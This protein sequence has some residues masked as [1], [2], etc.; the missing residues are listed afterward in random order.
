MPVERR[1]FRIE[2][3]MEANGERHVMEPVMDQQNIA[4]AFER[5]FQELAEIRSTISQAPLPAAE[6]TN[7][8]AASKPN[9]FMAE[10]ESIQQ[11]IW[12][13]KHEIVTLQVKGLRGDSANRVKDELDAVVSGTETATETILTAAE[14]IEEAAG[15]LLKHTQGEDQ[16]TAIEIHKQAI[17]IFEAC[18]FQDLTGQRITKVVQVLHFIEERVDS[19]MAI[20]GGEEGFSS[21]DAA[22]NGID[23]REGDA[24]LLNGPA[25]ATDVG[26]VS[27][28]D[29]DSLFS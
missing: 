19:M 4:K 22:S 27:Q 14:T 10:I 16:A 2:S 12:R 25:L 20:W 9:S 21:I 28:D 5:V 8:F 29:I 26:V 1:R 15:N 11:A 17:R 18:N 3:G 13:T 7:N 24:A 6:T 23:D